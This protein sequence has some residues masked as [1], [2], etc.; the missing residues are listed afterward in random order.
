MKRANTR[1]VPVGSVVIG[2]GHPIV[3]QS[4]CATKTQQV[5]ATTE[6]TRMLH[7]A[8]AGLVRIAVDNPKD[9]ACL[10]EVH[11][12]VPEANPLVDLQERYRLPT[13]VPPPVPKVRYN[14]RPPQHPD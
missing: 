7:E 1:A 10:A 9:V 5:D 11:A 8:G 3:V 12:R 13:P 14:P 2:G 6:Q 4:M